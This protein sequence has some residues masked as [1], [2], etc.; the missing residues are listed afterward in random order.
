[1]THPVTVSII[2]GN[3]EKIWSKEV[4]DEVLGELDS[5]SH[6]GIVLVGRNPWLVSIVKED[7][8][9]YDN[10][11]VGKYYRVESSKE[12][13]VYKC[14]QYSCLDKVILFVKD[15][16]SDFTNN[17]N[18]ID[19]RSGVIYTPMDTILNHSSVKFVEVPKP[20]GFNPE[21]AGK[22][23]VLGS[24]LEYHKVY[25]ALSNGG[26]A[27]KDYIYSCGFTSVNTLNF[28]TSY[29]YRLF[30]IQCKDVPFAE[31]QATG[32]KEV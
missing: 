18:F 11:K 30:T 32:W 7:G 25:K 9:T 5:F 3:S 15:I 4:L 20:E 13:D 19:T 16:P 31:V 8:I 27:L 17:F 29:E 22:K 28:N 12:N 14:G 21:F 26:I 24:K 10:L 1:M 2:K 6:N 23:I